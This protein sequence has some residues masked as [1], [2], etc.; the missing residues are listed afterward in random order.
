VRR[1]KLVERHSLKEQQRSFELV[2][3]PKLN[4]HNLQKQER[5]YHSCCSQCVLVE[6]I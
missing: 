4:N 5:M 2:L 3:Q 6:R 1:K